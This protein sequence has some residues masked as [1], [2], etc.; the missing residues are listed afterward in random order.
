MEQES[1]QFLQDLLVQNGIS[2]FEQEIQE[3]W[4]KRTNAYADS[5]FKDVHGNA[6]AVL[7]P[8]AEL[9]VM[10]AGHCDEIGFIVTHITKTG[11]IYFGPVG[12][13]DPGVIPG[14]QVKIKGDKGYIDGII[15]KKAIHM[16]TPEDRKKVYKLSDL[17]IDIGAKDRKDALKFVQVGDPV[18][19]S[20]NFMELKN[21]LFTSKACDNRTGAFIVSEVVKILSK[22]RKSLKV[23]VF[24]VATVQ[25]EV[26]L[27]GAWT[28]AFGIDPHAAIAVDVGHATDTP[29]VNV[30]VE[31]ETYLNKGPILS[32]G[33]V[34]NP[35]LGKMLIATAKSKKIP[36]QMRA[37]G[38][39]GGTD[40]AM[41]QVT[42]SGVATALVSVPNRYM[43]T[44]VETCAYNDVAN[45][46][47][48]IAETIL[49]IKP[50]T[51]FIPE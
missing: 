28:S 29:D 11:F 34:I 27:R 49:R 22:R 6:V 18:S 4:Q 46:A 20:P 26:G 2:G 44:A 24:S 10:L 16:M 19:V 14:T 32:H 45:C 41:I 43:H 8:K 31:G 33:P 40:T 13:I 1:K 23:G 38:R 35:V 47:K 12:G 25:E 5:V 36:Y 3:V 7:N 15:G 50:T 42:R 39:P 48:L 9:R 21:G 17:Y 30:R 51:S 37:L